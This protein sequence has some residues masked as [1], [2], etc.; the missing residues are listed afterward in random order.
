MFDDR[1]DDDVTFYARLLPGSAAPI[2][3][4]PNPDRVV[5]FLSERLIADTRNALTV[6]EAGH[7]PVQYIPRTDVRMDFLVRGKSPVDSDAVNYDAT[8]PSGVSTNV[9]WSFEDRDP[10]IQE[11]RGYVAFRSELVDLREFPA[12]QSKSGYS[13]RT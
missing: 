1:S 5:V 12:L 10:V 7:R 6:Y 4:E 2:T 3:V 11:L 13:V 8:T 9:A